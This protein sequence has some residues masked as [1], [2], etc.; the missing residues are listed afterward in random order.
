MGNA[1]R[2][3]EVV[4]NIV[5]TCPG[6]DIHIFLIADQ[7]D[8]KTIEAAKEIE[9]AGF[10]VSLLV[11]EKRGCPRCHNFS[12]KNCPDYEFFAT[13]ADDI[14]FHENWLKDALEQIQDKGVLA[15]AD[16]HGA[17][18]GHFLIRRSY[19][20]K[21]ADDKNPDLVFDGYEHEFADAELQFLARSRGEIFYSNIA[22]DHR[23]PKYFG[24]YSI[25]NGE[26][27][28]DCELYGIVNLKIPHSD[29]TCEVVTNPK[30]G[31]QNL[32]LIKI[33]PREPIEV[34]EKRE[35][36]LMNL[37]KDKALFESRAHLWGGETVETVFSGEGVS[38]DHA[39]TAAAS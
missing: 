14:V 27:L 34:G 9:R 2:I 29:I 11:S 21:Y 30:T 4:Q 7:S 5:E 38:R 39:R 36:H 16:K 18:W 6:L 20:E 8:F 24:G 31:F 12:F 13:V 26:K 37:S 32:L 22:L 19:I 28:V 33:T 17:G 25:V 10:P 23:N 15:F 3:K 35:R 1:A